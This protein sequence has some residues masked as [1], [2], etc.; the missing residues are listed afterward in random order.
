MAD[1]MTKTVTVPNISC[2]HC[3]HTIETEVGVLPGVESVTASLADKKVKVIWNSA[4]SWEK[5]KA[6]LVEIGYPPAE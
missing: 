2:G 1:A 3:V 5:I 4:T 6:T